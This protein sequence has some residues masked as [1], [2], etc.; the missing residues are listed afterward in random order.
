MDKSGHDYQGVDTSNAT[1]PLPARLL[2]S[3]TFSGST[4][5][6]ISVQ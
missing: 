5:G 1:V 3:P 4:I 2:A 6:D